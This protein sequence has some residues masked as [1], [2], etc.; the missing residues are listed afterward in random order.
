MSLFAIADTHLSFGTNKPMDTFEGWSNYTQRLEN[1]WN[2]LVDSEDYVII[3]GD[4]SWAMNFDELKADFA[5]IDSLKGKK[6]ILKGNHDYWWNTVKKMNEF[7]DLNNFKSISFLYN[8]AYEFDGFS[9]CGSRGWLLDSDE[10]QDEKVLRR[11][12][13][14]LE[15]SLDSAKSDEKIVFLHYP[16]IT[17]NEKCDDIL[18]LLV[19][20]GIKKCYYGHLHGAAAKYAVD[21]SINGVDF[22]LISADRLNFTPYLIKKF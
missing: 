17:T 12:V 6:I 22:K 15:M 8:N 3:A 4:I 16:P 9:V 21:D 18:N 11:E 1:N 14:R 19:K 10:Q 7:L 2:R 13:L 20:Y 5:F